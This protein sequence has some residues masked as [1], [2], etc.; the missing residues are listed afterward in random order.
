MATFLYNVILTAGADKMAINDPHG[1]TLTLISVT[2]VFAAL[3][4]L[5]FLYSLSGAVFSGKFK[6]NASTS[7]K[8]PDSGT[9]AAIALALEQELGE[10]QTQNTEAAIALA[11]HLYLSE[12]VHD[13]E[14]FI[15]T[16][17]RQEDNNWKFSKR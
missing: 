16:I 15:I 17:K 8:S 1:W 6:K 11:L 14:S 7:G 3:I 4:I 5:Y 2:V 13:R 10:K 9:I 12:S